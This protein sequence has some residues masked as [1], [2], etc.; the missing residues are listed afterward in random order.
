LAAL[1]VSVA[2]VPL[3]SRAG[4]IIYSNLNSDPA[5]VYN[6]CTGYT[7]SGP[8]SGVGSIISAMAFTPGA[9][10]DLSQID[11]A[12][13]Y[14]SGTNSFT[15]ELV[16]DNSGQPGS[17]VLES[18]TINSMPGLGTCCGLDTVT[19]TGVLLQGGVQYWLEA[20]PP[21]DL[22][23]AWNW[24]NTGAT[25][26]FAQSL[27]NGATWNRFNNTNGAFDVLGNVPTATPEPSAAMLLG[28]ALAS[29]L[30][31]FHLGSRR[32]G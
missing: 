11:L 16:N 12:M 20:V 25:G 8:T 32:S 14:V 19:S 22:F 28:T 29:M 24:N 15:L 17:T 3:T 10:Y 21:S 26:T 27:D 4:S 7:V 1:L 9:N 30:V 2:A 5:N 31:L 18:W 6:C 23:G 13:S